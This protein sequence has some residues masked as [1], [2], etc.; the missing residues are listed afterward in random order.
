MLIT[1][2]LIWLVNPTQQNCLNGK[3]IFKR[4]ETEYNIPNRLY[5]FQSDVNKNFDVNSRKPFLLTFWFKSNF[6]QLDAVVPVA[7]PCLDVANNVSMRL[8]SNN[9]IE[10]NG[11]AFFEWK[12]DKWGFLLL[13]VHL[14]AR[15]ITLVVSL[16]N[17]DGKL[18]TSY[19][20]KTA[21]L[22]NCY[23]SFLAPNLSE[24]TKF[25]G[26]LEDVT[27]Y[28]ELVSQR[29][30]RLLLQE[31]EPRIRFYTDFSTGNGI[32]LPNMMHYLMKLRFRDYSMEKSH[33]YFVESDFG[34]YTA[35]NGAMLQADSSFTIS[36][37]HDWVLNQQ[38][39]Y[40]RLPNELIT[41][42]ASFS[43][44]LNFDIIV[45]LDEYRFRSEADSSPLEYLTLYSRI[46][47]KDMRR[48]LELKA[49]LLKG[50]DMEWQLPLTIAAHDRFNS[51]VD[52]DYY[53]EFSQSTVLLKNHFILVKVKKN[54]FRPNNFDI[55]LMNDKFN[56]TAMSELAFTESDQHYIG[57]MFNESGSGIP[58]FEFKL[59]EFAFFENTLTLSN[60]MCTESSNSIRLGLGKSL[61]IGCKDQ[62][63]NILQLKECAAVDN[64]PMFCSIPGCDIC[65]FDGSYC[66][67]HKTGVISYK[68]SYHSIWDFDHLV[69]DKVTKDYVKALGNYGLAFHDRQTLYLEFPIESVVLLVINFQIVVARK[70]PN[71]DFSIYVDGE[72]ASTV[73]CRQ[74]LSCASQT[75]DV[76]LTV[77]KTITTNRKAEL[78]IVPVQP[79]LEY[80]ITNLKY[81]LNGYI[82]DDNSV[83][84]TDYKLKCAAYNEQ[85]SFQYKYLPHSE[86]YLHGICLET[87]PSGYYEA[88][89]FC[90]KCPDNCP[91][92][93]SATSC[94]KC[95]NE[96]T[97]GTVIYD[98]GVSRVISLH[99]QPPVT[100]ALKNNYVISADK[101]CV[102]C[103]DNCD[104][105]INVPFTC[106]TCARGYYNAGNNQCLKCNS[107]CLECAGGTRNDCTKCVPGKYV[108]AS[109]S[110]DPCSTNCETCHAK[111]DNC[112]LCNDKIAVMD[113]AGNCIRREFSNMFYHKVLN[114]YKKCEDCQLCVQNSEVVCARCP[115][116][117]KQCHV[118]VAF[119][120]SRIRI[121]DIRFP[122]IRSF[123]NNNIIP[124]LKIIDANTN[125][126]IEYSVWEIKAPSLFIRINDNNFGADRDI[127]WRIRIHIQPE[128]IRETEDCHITPIEYTYHIS[129]HRN[130]K[131]MMMFIR[132][133]FALTFGF[134]LL[135]AIFNI[136]FL[137]F[138][139]LMHH[140]L[141]ALNFLLA[142]RSSD[143][144]FLYE[145]LQALTMDFRA[146][147]I[148]F[149]SANVDQGLI[150]KYKFSSFN[151]IDLQENHTIGFN[152]FHVLIFLL[153][154][155]WLVTW[156]KLNIAR[157]TAVKN[158]FLP[159][160]L[161]DKKSKW[162]KINEFTEIIFINVLFFYAPYQTL[163]YANVGIKIIPDLGF[164]FYGVLCVTGFLLY[165]YLLVIVF[166][167][168]GTILKKHVNKHRLSYY[169][170]AFSIFP[171][172]SEYTIG[173]HSL[174]FFISNFRYMLIIIIQL[175]MNFSDFISG[176]IISFLNL[177][178]FALLMNCRVP[179]K[180]Y[181]LQFF[182]EFVLF[183]MTYM[184]IFNDVIVDKVNWIGIIYWFFYIFAFYTL[185]YSWVFYTTF[186]YIQVRK[187]RGRRKIAP[188]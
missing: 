33:E 187:W 78:N 81:G 24:S 111:Y 54:R 141:Y 6:N 89:D 85:S 173:L 104:N 40:I 22:D 2:F 4:I 69:Y 1:I 96:S 74:S 172:E 68:E 23:I 112:T 159:V 149:G 116:C 36:H 171:I 161:D 7:F 185:V 19:S 108:T 102:R 63:G 105:C 178:Y 38:G 62:E 83:L 145:V 134:G 77:L 135:L 158:T 126:P 26:A 37:S 182:S 5:Y 16:L 170:S 117:N 80:Y 103:F 45:K 114:L 148:R 32:A 131:A 152:L 98:E 44:Y 147:D 184:M 143:N 60:A 115:I 140:S 31:Q 15:K 139:I 138:V 129:L 64:D 43:I 181:Y 91:D 46:N 53:M 144:S 52:I 65:S 57:S 47:S 30:I 93:I 124:N 76:Y 97:H 175:T 113:E 119:I 162:K 51:V 70:D 150:D 133:V 12:N 20:S 50:F 121:L 160:H 168:Y 156:I 25:S 110:C 86:N 66:L 88:G 55:T 95:Y 39:R 177:F 41:D 101:R 18:M 136:K 17:D 125:M 169:I 100:N 107:E 13:S 29:D 155:T 28:D 3:R 128:L 49:S 120:Q 188:K 130:S 99:E 166:V 151:T 11:Q 48:G 142:L 73:N 180:I 56:S 109:G 82:S 42:A 153:G 34:P 167:R 84:A 186:I 137:T 154:A 127:N 164:S 27:I 92:C 8:T 14:A 61:E 59:N 94:N 71:T 9:M 35:E 106:T 157:Y 72:L 174:C 21:A 118:K 123:S 10:I 165:S 183:F 132:I 90:L 58:I 146:F 67:E 163:D 87:C 75:I 179:R 79:N 176:F 122:S